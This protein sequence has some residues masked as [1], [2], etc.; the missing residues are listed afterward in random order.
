MTEEK[1]KQ[2]A[3]EMLRKAEEEEKEATYTYTT[4]DAAA[5]SRRGASVVAWGA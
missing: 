4:A 5:D 3:G 1:R 2:Q